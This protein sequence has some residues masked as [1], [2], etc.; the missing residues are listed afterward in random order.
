MSEATTKFV[1]KLCPKNNRLIG[2]NVLFPSRQ[3]LSYSERVFE[4][5]FIFGIQLRQDDSRR[6]LGEPYE[7]I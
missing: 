3:Y 4:D 5:N 2:M 6:N 7:F 1:A